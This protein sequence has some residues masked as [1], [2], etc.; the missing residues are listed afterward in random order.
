MGNKVESE[1]TPSS[2]N[3][4]AIN[5]FLVS[6]LVLFM[7]LALIR[8]LGSEFPAVGFFKNLILIASF[9]GL[10][11]GLSNK[12]PIK[13][14]FPLLAISSLIPHGLLII[15]PKIIG[16][17]DLPY[18][19]LEDEAVLVAGGSA[20]WGI[21]LLSLSFLSTLLPMSFMGN[22]MG[23]YLDTFKDP[24]KGYGW[25]ILGS[26]FGIFLF[27][28]IS[29]Y[30]TPPLLW[31]G[32]GVLIFLLLIIRERDLLGIRT[33]VITMFFAI[34]T[35]P[36]QISLSSPNEIWSPY[37][38]ITISEMAYE[39]GEHVGYGLN[40]NKTWFQQSFDVENLGREEE[41]NETA[42][43]GRNLRF[44]AP[45]SGSS[46]EKILI[47]GS[48]LGNDTAI[49]I[50]AGVE[51][52]WAVDIDPVIISL[53]DVYHPNKP[54][55][56]ERVHIVI[57]DARHYLSST[58]EEFDLIIYGVLEARSLFSQFANLRLDNY[59][60]TIEAL[61]EA[62]DHLK[63]GGVLWL[64]MWV[65]QS[66]VLTKFD[67][68]MKEV[69]GAD[70]FVLHGVNSKHFSLVGGKEIS[71]EQLK[72]N[73]IAVPGVRVVETKS[74]AGNSPVT[75]PTDDWPYVFY[76]VKQLPSSF[77]AIIALLITISIIPFIVSSKKTF[78]IQWDYFFLG[79]GFLLIETWAVIRLALVAG[80][81]WLVNSS[82]FAGVLIFVYLANWI[83]S[84]GNIRRI[85]PIFYALFVS[86]IL[87]FLFPF[88]ILLS[89]PNN[90]AITL[91][92]LILT[93]PIFFASII[94]S[95]LFKTA[96]VPS[97]ALASNLLGAILG[98]FSEYLSMMVGNRMISLFALS[99][100]FLA[101]LFV[102]RRKRF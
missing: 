70:Y 97:V 99:L 19:G 21:L 50:R 74:I 72:N 69:F 47:V 5:L 90:L 66:W 42:A 44:I 68:M 49:A 38:N 9:V 46:Y 48:G 91:A 17:V 101:F 52:I 1:S 16:F 43:A 100:Y 62:K 93:V 102:V 6:V 83:V 78:K 4:N 58:D 79:A 36:F 82:V 84:R 14:T 45:F 2:S 61:G 28:L 80:T 33:A 57:D 3:G 81:T 53:S 98:G 29:Y 26:L 71:I 96:K 75:V 60:Y 13:T 11:I 56:N 18:F 15:F 41:L 86:L 63:P 87:L 24:L 73:T 27:S 12:Q 23:Y 94:Y 54:Y 51:E 35:I 25:N 76:R 92:A 10:G 88:N 89:L 32:I 30:S 31:F 95:T 55:Q 20:L 67:F 39:S 8:Y 7:E 22:L 65:P 85:E 40:V 34:L 37:Y 59:V 64:N 77:L